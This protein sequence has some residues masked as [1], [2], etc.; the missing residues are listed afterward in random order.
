MEFHVDLARPALVGRIGFTQRGQG[1]TVSTGARLNYV[2]EIALVALVIKIAQLVP[3][4]AMGGMLAQVIVGPMGHA[5]QFPVAGRGKRE[6]VLDITRARSLFGI[7]RQFVLVVLPQRQVLS[8]QPDGLP[9]AK[10]GVAPVLIPFRGLPRMNEELDFHLLELTRPE[11]KIARRDLV[12][13]RFTDLR[14]PK[15]HPHPIGI[16]HIPKL[17]KNSLGRLWA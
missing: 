4:A 11:R 15:R 17:G 1:A 7:V 6:T 9:P 16:E 5:F 13:E 8:R 12:A 14:N 10:T 2:R 3:L